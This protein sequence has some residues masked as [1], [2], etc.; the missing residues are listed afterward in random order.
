MT[1][2]VKGV[3][4]SDNP[5]YGVGAMLDK[6]EKTDI[7][8]S[9]PIDKI[10]PLE[11]VAY[12]LKERKPQHAKLPKTSTHNATVVPSGIEPERHSECKRNF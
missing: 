9:H 1:E 6:Y 2:L 7:I 11:K 4:C 3:A 8:P 5:Y 10:T 12:R